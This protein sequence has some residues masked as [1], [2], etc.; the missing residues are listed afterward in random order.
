M[1]IVAK[2]LSTLDHERKDDLM[3]VPD[4]A[5]PHTG[6]P[7]RVHLDIGTGGRAVVTAQ[8]ELDMLTSPT[9][10]AAIDE[11]LDHA[12]ALLVVDLTGTTFF[13][14]AAMLVLADSRRRAGGTTALRIAGGRI[15]RRV[16]DIAYPDQP[17]TLHPTVH[18]ALSAP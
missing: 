8:G 10:A 14:S 16:L 18:D 9:L 3:R 17:L 2:A 13:G 7:L 6:P 15:V 4:S 12:P 5:V 1:S 11:A